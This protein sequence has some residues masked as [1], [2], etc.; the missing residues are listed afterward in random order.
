MGQHVELSME[1]LHF[2]SLELSNKDS[3]NPHCPHLGIDERLPSAPRCLS[4]A[5]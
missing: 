1:V 2:I 4:V 5:V 3:K